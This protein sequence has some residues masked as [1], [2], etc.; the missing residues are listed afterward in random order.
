MPGPVHNEEV[1][2][3]QMANHEPLKASKRAVDFE[4]GVY[5]RGLKYERPAL[6]FQSDLWEEQACSRLSAEA[7]G[8]VYGS[9]GQRQTHNKNLESFKR[10]SIQPRRLVK[11]EDF[12]S[13]ETTIFGQKLSV[14]IAIAP[15]GVQRLFHREG[16]RAAARAAT[17]CDVPYIL[18]TASSTNIEDVA[19]ANGDGQRWFQ[20]YWPSNE[21]DDITASMLKRAKAAG[22]T[23]LFVT[24]DTYLLGWRPSDMDQGKF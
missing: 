22:Y 7:K 11:T 12:S 19:E 20:L 2:R 3:P 24:V 14:P 8:Y 18:S 21:H 17:K 15:V 9:A 23:T 10:W 1:H 6:T 16:E 5:K 4:Q 13:L